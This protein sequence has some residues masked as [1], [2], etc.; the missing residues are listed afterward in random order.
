MISEFHKKIHSKYIITINGEEYC[1][2]CDWGYLDTLKCD[3]NL[4]E[5]NDLTYQQNCKA[6]YEAPEQHC[7]SFKVNDE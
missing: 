3:N 5:Y 6:P 2:K 1:E 4:C 7:L